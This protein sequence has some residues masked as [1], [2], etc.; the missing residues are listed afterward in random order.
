[1]TRGTPAHAADRLARP[2]TLRPDSPGARQSAQPSSTNPQILWLLRI[3]FLAAAI[4]ALAWTRAD[5][6]LWGHVKYGQDIVLTGGLESTD[7]YSFTSD[8]PWI[9]HEWLAEVVLYLGYAS[10]GAVGLVAVKLAVLAVMVACIILALRPYSW[11]PAAHDLLIA[12]ALLGTFWRYHFLRPQLFSLLFFALLLLAITETK[13]GKRWPLV[14]IPCLFALWPNFHGGFLVGLGVLGVWLGMQVVRA[15]RQATILVPVGLASILATLATPYGTDLW[16]FLSDTVSFERPDIRDWQPMWGVSRVIQAP[17][18][19]IAL[20]GAAALWRARGRHDSPAL[21]VVLLLFVASLRVSRIDGFFALA[22]VMLLGPAFANPG[23]SAHRLKLSMAARAVIPIIVLIAA[24]VSARRA[25]CIEMSGYP[26]PGTTE[27]L[28]QFDGRLLT[29]FDW[30]QYAIWHLAPNMLVSMDGR[31]ETVY[32]DA[33]TRAHLSFYR[34]DPGS[35]SL[36]DSID[37][38]FIWLPRRLPVV[39]ALPEE[40]WTPLLEGPD[41]VVFARGVASAAQ[42]VPGSQGPR[43]FPSL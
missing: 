3:G 43:C 23:A 6:D 38:D 2:N 22:V 9:N 1:M 36:L 11:R 21:A 10:G 8:R 16:W 41:S 18:I 39:A 33:L 32:S 26:E 27:R 17:W 29:Y 13:G 7:P 31:R 19:V 40:G 30:G 42:Q 35:R 20:T 24:V 25:A 5:P 34:N 28:R 4:A 37:P 15:P 14:L 12:A